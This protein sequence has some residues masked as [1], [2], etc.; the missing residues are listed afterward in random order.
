[1]SA[2]P[3]ER[4]TFDR[5]EV[6]HILRDAVELD[7]R[8]DDERTVV[9]H[10]Q[11][12]LDGLTRAQIEEA[13]SAVG[14]S[15]AALSA[16]WMRRALVSSRDEWG[17]AHVSQELK[18]ALSP[19]ALAQ[20]AHEIRTIAG[21]AIIRSTTNGVELEVGA[22]AEGPASLTLR[23]HTSAGATTISVWSRAP[24]SSRADI[25]GCGVLGVPAF[26]FPVVAASG[27]HWPTAGI[28]AGLAAIG[29]TVGAGAG[30]AF[31]HWR[32]ARW[33]AR[34]ERIVVPIALRVSE[35]ISPASEV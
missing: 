31:S 33:H 27:G 7:E 17:R 19:A 14:I 9:T 29:A 30:A 22:P 16:A 26:L 25:A 32:I 10:A 28:A 21:P 12:A 6:A 3:P 11:P 5:D 23:I 34:V 35:K 1:M 2:T 8:G 24:L 18:G 15:A 4:S 20:L 13:A